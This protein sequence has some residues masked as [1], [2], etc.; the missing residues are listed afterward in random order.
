MNKK[1]N[2]QSKLR[3]GQSLDGKRYRLHIQLKLEPCDEGV[4]ESLKTAVVASGGLPTWEDTQIVLLYHIKKK[5][6]EIGIDN[7]FFNR[8]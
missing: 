5:L 4:L 7:D 6:Q 3:Y 2:E 8:A 1:Q